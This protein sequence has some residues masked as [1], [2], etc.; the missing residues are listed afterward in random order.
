[1]ANR[2]RLGLPVVVVLTTAA[3]ATI[4]VLPAANPSGRFDPRSWLDEVPSVVTGVNPLSE[5]DAELDGQT[6]RRQ[7]FSLQLSFL[8]HNRAPVDRVRLVGLD[9]YDGSL[10]TTSGT[11]EPA[12]T[13]CRQHQVWNRH[14]GWSP[15]SR[16]CSCRE[17]RVRFSRQWGG[18]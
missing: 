16:R 9:R 15:A 18:R 6:G 14:G 5:V 11:V 12:R 3:V 17:C 2:I 8:G 13:S 10:W 1:M 4:A 7:L